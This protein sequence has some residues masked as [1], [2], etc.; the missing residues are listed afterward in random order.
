[1]SDEVQKTNDSLS[2]KPGLF[3]RLI[4][5]PG[6]ALGNLFFQFKRG[7]V[8][9]RNWFRRLRRARTDYVVMPLGG[10]LPERAGPPRRFFQR[11]LPFPD[12]PFSV[13]EL[14]TRLWRIAQA[15]NV[16]G[17]ILVF[18]G[19]TAGLSTLQNVVRAITRLQEAGKEVIVYTPYLD[20]P[21]FL[22]A[23]AADR[24]IVPPGANFEVLGL[25]TETLFLKDALQRIGVKVDVIQ[26][27]PYKTAGNIVGESSITPE[28]EEQLS[29]L[30]DDRYDQ[31]TAGMATGRG[32]DQSTL[33]AMIDQA[34][35]PA[36]KALEKGLIDH[37]AYEDELSRLLAPQDEEKATLSTWPEA[38][39][40]MLEK[41]VR[42]S[43]QFIGVISLEG[44][45]VPGPS[46]QSPVDIPI[47]FVGGNLAGE[48]TITGLLRRVE[49]V[50]GMAA[51]ILHVDSPGGVALS[52]E[53]IGRQ[54][55]RLAHKMPVLVYMGNVAAS[56]GFYVAAPGQHIMCQPG[57][58]TGSIGVVSGRANTDG[59][60][61]ML[62]VNRTIL[63]RGARAGLYADSGELSAPNRAALWDMIVDT[64][65]RFKQVVAEGRN[66]P[67]ESLDA[68]C[69]GRVWTGRQAQEHQL[70]DSF[71]DFVDAI[72]RAAEMAG[73]PGDPAQVS[74]ANIYPAGRD[75][76]TI[77]Q[78]YPLPQ[79]LLA[80]INEGARQWLNGRPLT[81]MPF[82]F[83]RWW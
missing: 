21:H 9:L 51:L 78:P 41:V 48:E 12:P 42:R 26:I 79:E 16:P 10:T 5:L 59:L 18:T 83:Q 72:G 38:R 47:P 25:R 3:G 71:G 1:M 20:V 32:L 40:L 11:F 43:R 45:I 23:C 54:V 77:P 29:W 34:P 27:S 61:E 6:R 14:N 33:Q 46:R 44:T 35:F 15:E 37:V 22:V 19:F 67:F 69:E 53:L 63:S 74:V 31:I 24:I 68:I 70:V 55:E 76:F 52:A 65:T 2:Q 8:G 64:Y 66:L 58:L 82:T 17:V 13:Q 30:L 73:L 39:R 81:L 50:P 56:G 49:Q 36:E 7:R 62:Q 4:S 75:T 60:Y 80:F 57:T 28:H